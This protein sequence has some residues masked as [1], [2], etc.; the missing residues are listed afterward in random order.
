MLRHANTHTHTHRERERERERDTCVAVTTDRFVTTDR[1]TDRQTWLNALNVCKAS[2]THLAS[3]HA[4]PRR[5]REISHQSPG[6]DRHRSSCSIHTRT[7]DHRARCTHRGT[8]ADPEL[9]SRGRS[10]CRA[11]LPSPHPPFLPSPP[12]IHPLSLPV[13]PSLPYPSPPSF[14]SLSPLFPSLP[15]PPLEEGGPGSSPENFEIL[16]CCR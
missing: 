3:L 5:C 4:Q 9:V 15:S 7:R 14:P 11:P 6:P 10:P 8:G 16:D 13:L 1:Q 12:S 2:S